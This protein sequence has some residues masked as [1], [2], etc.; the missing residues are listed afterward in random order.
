MKQTISYPL[1]VSIDFLGH[2]K[3]ANGFSCF[4]I[5]KLKRKQ[6][7][8]FTL[9]KREKKQMD[10]DWNCLLGKF[11][12]SQLVCTPCSKRCKVRCSRK[13][14]CANDIQQFYR[15]MQSQRNVVHGTSGLKTDRILDL[16]YQSI[17]VSLSF[18][19][20]CDIFSDRKP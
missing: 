14:V 20:F 9:D 18:C 7:Y 13:T 11:Q 16:K 8:L 3:Y 6:P 5:R 1:F 10:F 17:Q 2:L 4:L 12:P 19:L 15:V